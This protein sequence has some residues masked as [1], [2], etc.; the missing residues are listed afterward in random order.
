MDAK[1]LTQA[2]RLI[3]DARTARRRFEG[4]PPALRPPGED[5]AYDV[6]DALREL[7][8]DAG[9]GRPAGFKI[10]CTTQVMQR[11][12]GIDH[13]CAGNVF[14]GRIVEGDAVFAADAF[15]RPGVECEIAVELAR[16]LS[17]AAAPFERAA[18]ARAVGAV[19]AAIEVVDDRYVDW[20]A[21]DAP[22]L[23]ADDFFHACDLFG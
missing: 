11:Y 8:T 16:P 20:R 22:T 13:P 7:L 18:V 1:S 12:L 21:M 5:A 23:V 17:A 19:R 3:A 10:G 4:L 9:F 2:A 14:T 6:Q 15:V